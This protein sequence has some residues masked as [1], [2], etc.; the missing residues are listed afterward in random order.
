MRWSQRLLAGFFVFAGTMHFVRPK[1]YEVIMPPY[2]PYHS[3]AVIVSGAAEIAGGLALIPAQMRPA[4]RW[5][6]IALLAAVFPAN[7]HMAL[8]PEEINGLDLER[9]KP[10]MLWARLPLQPLVMLW[11]WRATAPA[12]SLPARD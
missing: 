10:W 2:V 1:Y 6:L 5:W 11:V 9:I 7:L 12:E 8:N 4:A 3:E